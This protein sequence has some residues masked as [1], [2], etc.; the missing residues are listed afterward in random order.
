[1]EDRDTVLAKKA[2]YRASHKEELAAKQREYH[3]LH[4]EDL[5]YTE[6]VRSYKREW[7]ERHKHDSSFKSRSKINSEKFN[8]GHREE[9]NER[10][11]QRNADHRDE[12]NTR[13]REWARKHKEEMASRSLKYRT[14]HPEKKRQHY[15]A[16]KEAYFAYRWNRIARLKN[17]EGSHTA[18]D[19]ADLYKRQGGK[20]AS[21]HV[22]I[23]T[24][25]PGKFEID[26]VVAIVNGGT[27]WPYNLQL[28][29]RRCNRKK[30]TQDDIKW[31]NS[32]GKLF[33]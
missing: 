8:Q 2:A 33:C 12:V 11:R 17:A 7:Y 18:S 27:N 21:C 24:S 26:H 20:C 32:N 31:A 9:I 22:V 10:A 6:H 19:I 15:E 30:H 14:E 5:N 28:L 16:N 13:A 4:K 1:M 23:N 29:C 3:R 25:A